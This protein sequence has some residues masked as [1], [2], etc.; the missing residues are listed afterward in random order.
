MAR[1]E[2]KAQSMLNRW[3]TFKKEEAMRGKREDWGEKQAP[4]QCKHHGEAEKWRMSVVKEIADRITDIQNESLGEQR[5]RDL[6]DQINKLIKEK[7]DYE[8]RIFEL[9]G[10][11]LRKSE[12][13]L[14]EQGENGPV[15]PESDQKGFVYKYFGA[16]RNLP[17]V[18]SLLESRR[19]GKIKNAKKRKRYDYESGVINS[20]YFGFKIENEKQLESEEKIAEDQILEKSKTEWMKEQEKKHKGCRNFERRIFNENGLPCQF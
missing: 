13:A 2:E 4:A 9:G 8:K 17:E 10:R 5:I 11:D 18:K 7:G 15:D 3:R 14:L 12:S 1:N 19:K 20:Y 16:A 6:N